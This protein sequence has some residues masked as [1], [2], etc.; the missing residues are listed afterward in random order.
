[1]CVA[2]QCLL[3]VSHTSEDR[4]EKQDLRAGRGGSAEIRVMDGFQLFLGY[5]EDRNST[6]TETCQAGGFGRKLN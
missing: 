6:K 2:C 1:M 5:C 3:K 4:T